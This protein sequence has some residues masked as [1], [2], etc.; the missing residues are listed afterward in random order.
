[1]FLQYSNTL[2]QASAKL[3]ARRI[4]RYDSPELRVPQRHDEAMEIAEALK[5]VCT[6]SA[7]LLVLCV[8]VD[9]T[10]R[11]F[12]HLPVPG[13]FLVNSFYLS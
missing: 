12:L 3:P 9:F 13:G 10:E 4:D 7:I 8:S 5:N 11:N 6:Q 2:R 1:M